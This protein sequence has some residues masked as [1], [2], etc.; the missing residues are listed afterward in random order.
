M[1]NTEFPD[2]RLRAPLIAGEREML[3]RWLDFHRGTLQWK[4]AGLSGDQLVTRSAQPSTM[5]L[6][7]LVRHMAEVER[8]WFRKIAGRQAVEPRAWTDEHPDGDFDLVDPN[9]AEE[10]LAILRAEIA[11]ADEAARD[12][13][14]DDVF[15]HPNP[16]RPGPISLRWI[17]VHMIEEYARHNGHADL[18]RERIDGRT[19][20]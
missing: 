7:G 4:C 19:G 3:S 1:T 18:L 6:L 13:D 15:T 9:R 10:D 11:A 12:L 16:N 8:W 2:D 14:L 17:Y 20:E 5:T